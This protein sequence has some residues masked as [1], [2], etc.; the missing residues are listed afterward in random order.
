MS[1]P[2]FCPFCGAMKHKILLLKDELYF[3]KECNR[4]FK[5]EK[6]VV[7]CPKC[8]SPNLVDSEFPSPDGEVIIQCRGCRK[9]YT[10]KEILDHVDSKD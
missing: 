10:A 7:R 6:I 9:M 3:C 4:F 5:F 2:D 8:N 1:N